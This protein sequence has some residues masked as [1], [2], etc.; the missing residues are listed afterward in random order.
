MRTI[1]WTIHVN[2]GSGHED[3]QLGQM[4]NNGTS[5]EDTKLDH[6][7]NNGTSNENL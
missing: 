1:S 3:N 5:H 2:N 7:C 6:M 4:C